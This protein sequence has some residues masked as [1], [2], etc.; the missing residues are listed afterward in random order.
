MLPPWA[1]GDPS[2]FVHFN[3]EALES[4]MVSRHLPAWIDL[5]F[6]YKQRDP[7]SF[8]CFHPLSYR[9]AVDLDNIKDESE[10][11]ASTAII[12]N[13]GQTPVQ[14][15]KNPHPSKFLGG[16]TTL[17]SGTRFGVAEHWQMMLRS[18]LP[19]TESI[20]PIH[21]IL[22]PVMPEMKPTVH[23]KYRLGVP[24][25]SHLS[26]QYGFADESIRVYFQETGQRV[27]G[28]CGRSRQLV[29]ITEGIDVAHASFVSPT[30]LVTI[31]SLGV[32]TAWRLTVKGNGYKRGETTLVREATLRGHTGPVTCMA[33]SSAWCFLVTGSEVSV[34]CTR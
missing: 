19:I 13:F 14:I 2:L 8:N 16:R 21:H 28:S 10:K 22:D 26:L 9:G 34:H 32:I 11:A 1:L 25:N 30:L 33:V 18:I 20:T 17:P 29:Y 27:G 6:G 12:H 5:T 15:F 3:R 31:S 24:G 23:Q 4:D 7:A